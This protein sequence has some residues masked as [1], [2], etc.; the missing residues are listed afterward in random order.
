MRR[1]ALINLF[2]LLWVAVLGYAAYRDLQV[3]PDPGLLRLTG[4]RPEAIA[5]VHIQDPRGRSVLLVRE[6]G[7][8]RMEEPYRVAAAAEHVIQLL[9]IAETPRHRSFS[10]EVGDLAPYGLAPPQ[11]RLTLDGLEI[12]LGGTEPVRHRRYVLV[13]EV[14]GLIDDGFYPRL[15]APAEDFVSRRVL[16]PTVQV[17]AVRSRVRPL[18]LDQLLALHADRVEPLT[19][20]AEGMEL[21][22]ALA[23]SL[24]GL[25]LILSPDRR[26]LVRPDLGLVYAFSEPIPLR[27]GNPAQP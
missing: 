17:D 7:E 9:A 12:G 5:R 20:D 25:R 23:G 15:R 11:L 10:S 3:P 1:R 16:G 2:L 27:R 14:I 8:W 4:L 6:Q 13:G 19:E 21:E 24:E 18:E 22:V 26:R